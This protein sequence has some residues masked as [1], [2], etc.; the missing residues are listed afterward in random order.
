ML[1]KDFIKD[2]DKEFMLM[3][4]LHRCLNLK[5]AAAYVYQNHRDPELYTEKRILYLLRLGLILER[6]GAFFL[7]TT[8]VN[9]VKRWYEDKLL[10]S[11]KPGKENKVLPKSGD[12]RICSRNI[13]H[14]LHLN[15]FAL[16]LKSYTPPQIPYAYFD[17]K[18]MP[19]AGNFIMPD[20]M[21]E[22]G[23]DILFL[24]MDMGTES[25]KRLAQ[26]WD[27]YRMFLNDPKAYYADKKISMFFIIEGMTQPQVRARNVITHMFKFLGDRFANNFECYVNAPEQCHEIIKGNFF[28]MDTPLRNDAANCIELMTKQYGFTISKPGFFSELHGS[29]GA[30]AR[31]HAGQ[32]KIQIIDGHPQEFIFDIW[33]NGRLSILRN[34]FFWEK[35]SAEITKRVGREMRYL[36]IVPS[37]A[38]ILFLIKCMKINMPDGICFS[39]FD[40]LKCGYLPKAFFTIDRL[41]NIVHFSD[42]SYSH[43][44]HEKRPKTV[45]GN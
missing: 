37:E 9:H 25:A 14:Q 35:F 24:E 2:E 20:G 7:S 17:E 34:I 36:I 12:L 29:F 39:T 6:E 33:L 26:K 42:H 31:K 18:F 44:I 23:R 22:V 15:K 38:W 30:Y 10:D 40:R 1:S 11:Y 43:T 16:E 32:N 27:S 13:N 28:K 3:L 8:G 45:I 19:P 21:Y 41:L 5:L 4:Y